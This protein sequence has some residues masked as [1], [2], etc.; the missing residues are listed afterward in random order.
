MSSLRNQRYQR[1]AE[2]QEI[3]D[4]TTSNT[5]RNTCKLLIKTLHKLITKQQ[6][7]YRMTRKNKKMRK[8]HRNRK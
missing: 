3:S 7:E 8:K 5:K 1:I 4:T 6:Q 2:L